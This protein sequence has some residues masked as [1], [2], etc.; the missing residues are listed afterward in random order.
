MS[1]VPLLF[2]FLIMLLFFVLVLFFENLR[3]IFA[4]NLLLDGVTIPE[5]PW[6]VSMG[7]LAPE[8]SRCCS[9]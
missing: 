8:M 6:T 9:K 4:M 1:A 3:G 7:V 2:V 5:S